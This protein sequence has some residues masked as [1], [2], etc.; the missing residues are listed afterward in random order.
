MKKINLPNGDFITLDEAANKTKEPREPNG[1]PSKEM[2]IVLFA[3]G[4]VFG[5]LLNAY[6]AKHM[7]DEEV[8][9]ITE[10]Q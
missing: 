8:K 2:G 10:K 1:A 5:A 3:A 9:Q 7:N 4:F 6:V